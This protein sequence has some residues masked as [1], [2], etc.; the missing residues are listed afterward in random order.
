MLLVSVQARAIAHLLTT[1]ERQPCSRACSDRRASG[2]RQQVTQEPGRSWLL[3]ISQQGSALKQL[4]ADHV[5]LHLEK[6]S[7]IRAKVSG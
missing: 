5:P 1:A 4:C 2:T 7:G 6:E 3:L